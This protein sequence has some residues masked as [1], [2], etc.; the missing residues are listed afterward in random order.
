MIGEPR[1]PGP[2]YQRFQTPQMFAIERLGRAQIHGHA[3]LHHPVLLQDAIENSQR[4][5]AIQHVVFRNNLE[6]IDYRLALQNV[7]VM[8]NAQADPDAVIGM[9]VEAI[10]WHDY[11]R[12]PAGLVTFWSRRWRNRP[13]PCT[14]SCPCN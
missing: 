12:T 8:R 7:L 4:P 9:S 1:R 10:G 6:P 13:Y 11:R 5:P 3:M 2:L 14:S